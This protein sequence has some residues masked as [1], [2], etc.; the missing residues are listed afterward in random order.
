MYFQEIING[1]HLILN[2]GSLLMI[3]GGI[4]LGMLVGSLPGL[5]ATMAIAILIPLSF[6]IP[7]LLGIPFLVGIYKGGL[8][9]G[10]IPAILVSTPGTGGA[11]ATVFDGYAMAQKGKAKKAIQMSL[12]ASTVGDTLSDIVLFMFM[13]PL[14]MVALY[15]GSPEYFSLFVFSLVLIAGVTGQSVLKGLFSAFV[16]LIVSTIGIDSVTGS[17]RFIFGNLNMASGMTFMTMLIGLFAISEILIQAERGLTLNK[18]VGV[19]TKYGKQ[20]R[21]TWNEFWRV[22]KV[23]I[24]STGIGTFI[25]IIPGLGAPIAAFLAYS[26]AKRTS[27]T[28]EAFGQG[29]LEG[30]AAPE[31]A[32]SAV[33]GAN[34]LPLFA[35]GIP[36]D[37]ITAVMLGAFIVHGMR[38]GPDLFQNHAAT[39]YAIIWGMVFAN[40]FL[41]VMGWALSGIYA[42]IVTIPKNLLFP[43]ILAI[44][45]VGSYSVNN[46]MFDVK[47]MIVF[48]V[49]GYLMK[50]F[51]IPLAPLIITALLGRSIENSLVQSYIVLD[52]NLLNLFLRP[53][54]ALF[55][56]LAL[57]ILALAF[58][59]KKN[60]NK[61]QQ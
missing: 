11:A 54:S 5:T 56:V 21:L 42:K 27:K 52:G 53:I 29:T 43:G 55:I 9:G 10:A 4:L 8:Y 12:V 18:N 3:C 36:G 60:K 59:P 14:A 23:I 34:F 28:P 26:F 17:S 50:K 46:N 41:L 19:N 40:A 33:N 16:G 13:A 25:G 57:I 6:S 44:A 15:F 30:V 20:D 38:P 7:P 22:K 31:A 61:S 47:L 24:Q 58:M 45:A 2:W 39:M 1:L 51:E 49:I 37:I 48:G 35:F 32:N